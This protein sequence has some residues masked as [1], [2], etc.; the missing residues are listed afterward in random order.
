MIGATF[1]KIAETDITLGDI[2]VNE[3]FVEL[4]DTVTILDEYGGAAG[5]YVYMTAATA[6]EF[7]LEAGWYDGDDISNWDGESELES[8]NSVALYD[9][10]AL[11]VEVSDDEAS[12]V[13]AGLVPATAT[14]LECYAGQKTFLSNC[15]PVD[16]T[17]SDITV[18]ETFGEISDTL[19]VLN[20]FG[21]AAG[22][23]VYMTAATAEEFGLEAGW[24]DGDEVSNWDGESELARKDVALP[25]GQG[26]MLEVGTD[27][28]GI[29][30]P[31]AF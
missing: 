28:A 18:N 30:V 9:G 1:Q 5:V 23:Y 16:R 26:F 25:A 3:S 29:I 15:T 14:E 31:A 22:V 13:F 12:L 19:T 10:E 11:M 8:K 6:E 7:G 21:G 4:S 27:G 20:E 17:L 2:G 24:Y